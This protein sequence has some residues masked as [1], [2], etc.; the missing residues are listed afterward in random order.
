MADILMIQKEYHM[1][2]EQRHAL[3]SFRK[4]S[5][6][7]KCAADMIWDSFFQGHW[8]SHEEA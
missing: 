7:N 4:S 5:L 8:V 6:M 1:T 3:K 2:T